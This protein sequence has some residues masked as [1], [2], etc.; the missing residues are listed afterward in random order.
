ML[1]IL[2]VRQINAV[3]MLV[4][5]SSDDGHAEITIPVNHSLREGAQAA[6]IP[7]FSSEPGPSLLRYG[8]PNTLT[9]A[10]TIQVKEVDTD[11]N[12]IT[13]YGELSDGSSALLYPL[14]GIKNG[15]TVYRDT[16]GNV[17][18]LATAKAKIAHGSLLQGD[19]DL[20]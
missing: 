9:E 12:Q 3:N 5:L 13:V 20:P 18:T 17:F 19:I 2:N 1:T 4:S 15:D 14:G 16:N 8:S 6:Q 7:A 10:L 11:D